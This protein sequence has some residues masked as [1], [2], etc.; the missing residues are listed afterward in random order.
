MKQYSVLCGKTVLARSVDA[1]R[2][3]GGG[4]IAV[5]PVGDEH[6]PEVVSAGA[7]LI[8]AGG[9]TRSASVRAGLSVVPLEADVIVIHDAAR[10]LAAAGLFEAVVAAVQAG[11]DGAICALELSDTIKRIEGGRVRETIERAG[12]VAVQTP[13]AFRADALREAHAADPEATDDAAVVEASG[14]SVVVVAGHRHNIK[15]TGPED[16]ELAEAYLR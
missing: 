2:A 8:V 12:L 9:A 7:D 10:P 6:R 11:A 3:A 16:L 5:V 13:Q 14:G 4:V 1:A 15:L